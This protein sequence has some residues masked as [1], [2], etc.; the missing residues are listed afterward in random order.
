MGR[1]MITNAPFSLKI[2]HGAYLGFL[3]S[4]QAVDFPHSKLFI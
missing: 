2:A 1:E 4:V 3:F